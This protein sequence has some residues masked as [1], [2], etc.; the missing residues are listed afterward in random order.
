MEDKRYWHLGTRWGNLRFHRRSWLSL[1]LIL[2]VLMA[3]TVAALALGTLHI[4]LDQTLNALLFDRGSAGHLLVVREIRLPRVAAALVAGAAFGASGM[5]MQGMA[6]NR[7]ATPE[8]LGINDG[9]A[10]AMV[11]YT[12]AETGKGLGPWW[13]PCAGA[14]ATALF[15]V[16]AAGGVGIRG[17]RVLVVGIGI[18][19]MLRAFSEL[20]VSRLNLQHASVIYDWSM[21]S[22]GLQGLDVSIPVAWGMAAATP[23]ILLAGQRLMVMQFSEDLVVNL[24]VPIGASRLVIYFL[25]VILAAFAVTLAGPVSFVAL[26]APVLA[27]HMAG[28]TRIP[29]LGASA[30][31]ALLVLGA[32]ALGRYL[33]FPSQIPVGVVTTLLGGPFLLWVLLREP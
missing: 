9:A 2:V 22:V 27:C 16:G 31:G 11:L 5:L 30:I 17:Y 8:F 3:A 32:D 18:S 23:L 29:V 7:L 25:A 1:A 33:G 21:G 26:A 19:G 13:I 14:L 6:R 15:L 20:F 24:G 10:L 12:M 4:G 28:P